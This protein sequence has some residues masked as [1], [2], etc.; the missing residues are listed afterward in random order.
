M[1]TNLAN[2][3]YYSWCF[4]LI[5]ASS[6]ILKTCIMKKQILALALVLS[7][8]SVTFANVNPSTTSTLKLS[9][10]ETSFI[11]DLTTFEGEANYV[12][13][14]N[15]RRNFSFTDKIESNN[16]KIKYNLSKL[17]TGTYTVKIKGD[18]T[19]EYYT[20]NLDGY[21]VSIVEKETY[22]SPM[23]IK[24]TNKIIVQS[25]NTRL[26]KLSFSIF[27][28]KGNAIYRKAGFS[29]KVFNLKELDQGEYRILVSDKEFSQELFVSL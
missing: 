10:S 16:Q 14:T 22:S 1:N 20:I 9:P 8:I 26:N 12:S 6:L 28:T 4:A 13:V 18:K 11:V 15:E 5:F 29:Q 7:A 23:I 17:R 2:I 3:A 21:G 24:D 25:T 27:D 19:V